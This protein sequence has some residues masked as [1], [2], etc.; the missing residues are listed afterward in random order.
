[1]S[2]KFVIAALVALLVSGLVPFTIWG[3]GLATEPF[4]PGLGQSEDTHSHDHSHDPTAEP[5]TATISTAAYFSIINAGRTPDGLIGVSGDGFGELTLH[6]TQIDAQEIA[7]MRDL[8]GVVLTPHTRVDFAPVGNHIMIDRLPR[9]LYEGD[10][11][12]L[13]LHFESGRAVPVTFDVMM[14]PPETRLNFLNAEGFQISNSWVR[15]TRSLD[16]PA[17]TVSGA[18]SWVLPAGF[19]L[20]RVSANNPMTAEKVELG[21]YLFYDVRLSGNETTSCSSCHLQERAFTDGRALAVGSTGDVHPRNA[22]TLTNVAYNATLNWAHPTMLAMEQQIVV[23]MFGEHPVEMGITGHEDQVLD[24]FRAD[25]QYRQMF[26]AAFPEQD[27]PF[28]FH[29]IVLALASF[30]RTLISGSSSY[31]RYLAGERDA[32]SEPAWR[33]MELFFSESFECHHCHTGFNLS[34]STVSAN[35]TFEERP[36][37]NTGLYNVD[38]RGAYPP[39][40][41]GVHEI[42]NNPADMGRF[43]PPTLRNI[44]LTAPYM[45]D[46]SIGSLEEVIRFYSDGGRLIADGAYAG[47]GRANPYKSG[48]VPGFDISDQEVADLVAFLESLTDESF[49]R[50]PHLSD[51]FAAERDGEAARSDDRISRR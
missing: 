16:G 39:D 40:N 25:P 7:R 30:N 46:G 29:N 28:T 4:F 31:D 3:T 22:P 24:R 17:M 51:P 34:L 23:P 35:T 18:Y 33:G 12:V 20:P 5:G 2:R 6:R 21:R 1:M 15:A 26:V 10:Q 14:N 27:D 19:P 37:F 49:I 36:F 48:L 47:D 43:R 38:G 13:T 11:V 41:T 50:D 42:T 44:A 9:D 8:D 45:H 32:L